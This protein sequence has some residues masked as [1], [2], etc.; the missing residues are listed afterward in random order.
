MYRVKFLL[1][2][3]D[4]NKLANFLISKGYP[5]EYQRFT[6]GEDG[7]VKAEL[8]I[9]D[10]KIFNKLKKFIENL[11]TPPELLEWASDSMPMLQRL[12]REYAE[13]TLSK[14]LILM[15]TYFKENTAVFVH[16]LGNGSAVGYGPVDGGIA[17]IARNH[18]VHEIVVE[19]DEFGSLKALSESFPLGDSNSA[20]KKT[21]IVVTATKSVFEEVPEEILRMI[22][23]I[24]LESLG[25]SI[26]N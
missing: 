2:E 20:I 26:Q 3:Q 9:S 21:D 11:P 5:K 1:G 23:R 24:K 17:K 16:A 13:I 25:Y 22:A 7:T 12:A 19:K 10:I 15:N 8:S 4:S 18:E 6:I 14:G